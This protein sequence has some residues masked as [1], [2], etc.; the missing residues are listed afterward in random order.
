MHAS[1][2]RVGSSSGSL[3]SSS[4]NVGFKAPSTAVERV[5]TVAAT[6]MSCGNPEE[7]IKKAES[8]VRI[9]SSRGAQVILL[10]ELF[11]FSYFPIELNAGNFQLATTLEESA[12][13]QGMALLAKELHVVIPISFFERRN[14][15]YYNSCAVIDADGTV[16]GVARKMHIGDRLGYNEKYYFT[17]SD[18]SFKVWNTRYGK[19][20]VAI[21]SDQWYP[22]VARSLVVQGAELLLYPSAMGSNQYDP[23]FDPRDQWQRVMQG[24]A[25]ASM[26]PVI[27][28]N[29][30]GSE[31]V[32]GI[33]VTFVGS[34]FITGQT[35]EMLKIADR[36]SEVKL[37][38]TT[39]S[40]AVCNIQDDKVIPACRSV[41]VLLPSDSNTHQAMSA[42]VTTPGI[43]RRGNALS[44]SRLRE[45][46]AA[47]NG[48]RHSV[49]WVQPKK[50]HT[51]LP[52]YANVMEATNMAA[53]AKKIEYTLLGK[54]TGD[55]KDGQKH[56]YGA[57]MYATG[58]KYEGE[59]VDNKRQGRGV[60]WV[61][62]KKKLRKQYAGEWYNDHRHGRGTSFHEDGGKYEGQ[63]LNNK[64]HGH[65]RMI[66]GEDQS[67]YD[68]EW[69][70]NER[71]GRGTLVLANGDRYE[72]HWL[73]GK[74]EGPGRYF[75]KATRKM[76]EGEW[77][78]DA[79]KCGTY[80]DD[81]E[82]RMH[83]DDHDD[84]ESHNAFQLPELE[85]AHPEQVLS[86][87]V[88][89]IRQDR[90]RERAFH[91]D[92][93]NEDAVDE[94]PRRSSMTAMELEPGAVVFDEQ[95]LRAIQSEFAA[96]LAEQSA[97][98]AENT[99]T[100]SAKTRSGCIPC[101]RLPGLL[102]VLQLDVSE[103]QL[104]ELLQEI[105]ATPDTLVSF[106]ECVDIL[107][108]LMESQ[109]APLLEQDED[110]YDDD[111]VSN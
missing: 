64:R 52:S 98:M 50:G 62:E 73:N 20:G 33:Q 22:E 88:A 51:Q 38:T 45:K 48:P 13:V 106:A 5:M 110:E 16:L 15:S 86:E 9:A 29:R 32:D 111:D 37:C 72:G 92:D 100:Q 6:Q 76:Y 95:M 43:G 17:P 71:S 18:D 77:V 40:Q 41:G 102:D 81:R 65:G 82:F 80:H 57:L 55:W 14:N 56:G 8:L 99:D 1:V 53:A 36:E 28:S 84:N 24:H 10:Q 25:A 93:E 87:G 74:K 11:Q 2:G 3:G 12:L 104:A 94:E 97:A 69:L 66:Y 34:S 39:R 103:E 60:Y 44:A 89:G 85:L 109:E 59:W 7:N 35:G 19:I 91:D 70:R 42:K 63:W 27:C 67:V 75:Y 46:L 68:G 31:V 26:V 47:R 30:V 105:G 79:P 49:Y 54:Y 4:A 101:S 21:G 61:E 78:D 96:L 90:V 107:S 83:D 58:N 23:N 108:L